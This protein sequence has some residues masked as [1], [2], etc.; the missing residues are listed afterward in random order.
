MERSSAFETTAALCRGDAVRGEVPGDYS[1]LL[2]P[3]PT[4]EDMKLSLVLHADTKGR[5]YRVE[6]FVSPLTQ[7]GVREAISGPGA[8]QMR[9]VWLLKLHTAEAK[10]KL[11][12]AGTLRVRYRLC[13]IIDP[14]RRE[15]KVKVHWV[16]FGVPVDTVGRAFESFGELHRV[17]AVFVWASSWE[18]TSRTNLFRRVRCGALPLTHLFIRQGV[19]RFIFLCDQTDP[20]LRTFLQVQLSGALPDF[21]VLCSDGVTGPLSAYLKEVVGAYRFLATRFSLEYLSTVSRKHLTKDLIDMSF[22]PPPP[23]LYRTLYSAFPGKYVLCRVKR[24]LV[25]PNTETFCFKL[26]SRTLPVKTWLHEKG[27]FVPWTV[28]CFLCKQPESIEHVF[29][30][31]YDAVFYWDVL[32]RTL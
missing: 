13:L 7:V 17:F 24:M 6:D 22:S 15:L 28:N 10:E 25:P 23:P 16:S 30:D 32:Q 31:C 11:L 5:P 18:R 27:I 20:F 3:L 1:V 26:H 21:V 19:N 29:L 9:H 8:F 14:D 12:S 4:G 2:P